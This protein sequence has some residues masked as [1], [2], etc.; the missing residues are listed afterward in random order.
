M[1]IYIIRRVLL[2]IPTLLLITVFVFLSVRFIPSSVIDMMMSEMFMQMSGTE[3]EI[4]REYLEQALG[5][6]KPIHVQYAEWLSRVVRGDLGE[7]LW[8]HRSIN[9]ELISKLPV[10]IELGLIAIRDNHSAYWT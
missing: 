3:E 2:I 6:D 10:S 7:S 1:Q 9:E 4:S 8:T 5:L